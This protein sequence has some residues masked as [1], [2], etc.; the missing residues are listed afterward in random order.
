M[1]SYKIKY[2][3]TF[4]E[5]V[6]LSREVC[7]KQHP[8]QKYLI[9]IDENIILSPDFLFYMAQTMKSLEKDDTISSI[10]AWSC[11]CYEH[12]GDVHLA[13]RIRSFPRFAV[14]LPLQANDDSLFGDTIVPDV[15]RLQGPDACHLP[16]LQAGNFLSYF[17]NHF[18][19]W[20]FAKF[21]I[22][23]TII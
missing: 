19:L 4:Q 22:F 23:Q 2:P 1:Q 7:K 10:S 18:F 17:F 16:S 12:E 3:R 8:N 6:K 15:S 21:R 11:N 13:Y 20:L 5:R 9:V 14:L